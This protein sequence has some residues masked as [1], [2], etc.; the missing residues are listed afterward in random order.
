LSALV[1]FCLVVVSLVSKVSSRF[2]VLVCRAFTICQLQF[3]SVW[4]SSHLFLRL[5]VDLVY[6][7]VVLSGLVVAP[8]VVLHRRWTRPSRVIFALFLACS[9][10]SHLPCVCSCSAADGHCPSAQV[11][12]PLTFF[13]RCSFLVSPAH[14]F[15]SL[16]T[17]KTLPCLS[18]ILYS[19]TYCLST[20]A[21]RL[22]HR[23]TL[24]LRLQL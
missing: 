11:P 21:S 2:G 8:E 13:L 12:I 17:L 9:G 19:V 24:P 18:A 20:S 3:G 1:R 23:G 7:F 14:R 4:L 10:G 5:A 6:S 15:Q 16:S 22:S